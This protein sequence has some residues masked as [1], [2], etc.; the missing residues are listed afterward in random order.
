MTKVW[1]VEEKQFFNSN[2]TDYQVADCGQIIHLYSS[3]SKAEKYQEQLE[4]FLNVCGYKLKENTEFPEKTYIYK[5]DNDEGRIIIK[6]REI[7]VH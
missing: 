1:Y 5:K 7:E 4:K 2:G 3:K 6:I